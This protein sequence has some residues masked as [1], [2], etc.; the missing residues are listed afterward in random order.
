MCS[1]CDLASKQGDQA[2]HFHDPLK[3]LKLKTLASDGEK[4]SIMSRQFHAHI[5]CQAT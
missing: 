5:L 3:K 4:R 2:V 1:M